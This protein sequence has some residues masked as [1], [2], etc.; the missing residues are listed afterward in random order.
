MKLALNYLIGKPILHAFDD[1]TEYGWLAWLIGNNQGNNP[2]QRDLKVETSP[3]S[4]MQLKT[5]IRRN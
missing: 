4:N 2:N 3:L 5:L 1:G